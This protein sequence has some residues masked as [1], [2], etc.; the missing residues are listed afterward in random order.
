MQK[1]EIPEA[2]L[3]NNIVIISNISSVPFNGNRT[4]VAAVA[5]QRDPPTP[6]SRRAPRKPLGWACK[7]QPQMKTIDAAHYHVTIT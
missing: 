7:I 1:K 2:L 4:T 6:L 3:L 5:P